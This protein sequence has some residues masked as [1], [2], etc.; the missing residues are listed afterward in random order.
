MSRTYTQPV[1]PQGPGSDHARMMCM[2][3]ASSIAKILQLY[4]IRY[5]LRRMA[6]HAVGIVCSAALLLVFQN[7]TNYQGVDTEV[8]KH[9]LSTCFR[10]LEQFELSWESAKR[11]RDFLLLLQRQWELR[12]RDA[13]AGR[14]QEAAPEYQPRKRAR[15]FDAHETQASDETVDIPPDQ[16]V[17]PSMLSSEWQGAGD[18]V[19]MENEL[20]LDWISSEFPFAMPPGLLD[21]L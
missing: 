18:F 8:V 6:V 16:L 2:E 9:N 13:R 7:I 19:D 17:Q 4:E 20:D 12:N 14:R 5:P 15:M 11:A 21:R 3:S 10:A 1:P